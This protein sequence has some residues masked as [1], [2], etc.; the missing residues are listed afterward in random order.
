MN[1]GT[2]WTCAFRFVLFYAWFYMF[3]ERTR[4]RDA[5]VQA[6]AVYTAVRGPCSL[7][8]TQDQVGIAVSPRRTRIGHRVRGPVGFLGW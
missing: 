7:L 8:C 1:V 2:T 4:S 5:R 3:C 6:L